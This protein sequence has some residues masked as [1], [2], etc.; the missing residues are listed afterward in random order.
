MVVVVQ[1]RLGDVHRRQVERLRLVLQRDDELVTGTAL[2]KCELEARI[3]QS[4]LQVVG[5]QRRV[6]GE[7]S[8]PSRPTMRM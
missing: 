8:M 7:R 6:L 2:R 3:P 5:V 4:R 1:Q